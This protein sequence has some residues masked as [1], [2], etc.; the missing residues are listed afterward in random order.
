MRARRSGIG[1]IGW[2]GLAVLLAGCGEQTVE[3]G[4]RLLSGTLGVEGADLYYQTIGTGRPILVVHGGPGLD[5]SYLRPWL[6][7]LGRTHR[8]ILYDQR[9]LGRSAARLDSAGITMS[10]FLTDIDRLRERVAGTERLVLL[11]HS[12]GAIP[13]LL[14]AL[15]AP[16]RV[17]A[18]I[19]VGSVEPGSRYQE[20]TTANQ[21]ERRDPADR[22]AIDSL[23]ASPAFG[24][25]DR[26]TYNRL[27]FHVFRGTFADP[28]VADSLLRLD[29]QPRTARQG[30]TVARRLMGP[31]QGLDF[32][33]ELGRIQAPV[34]LVH[35]AEDPIPLEMVRELE[36][37]LPD[38]RLVVLEGAGHFPFIETPEAFADAVLAFLDRLPSPSP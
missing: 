7:P 1:R 12:W 28:S 2:L 21:A 34:L 19:L 10:R 33:D 5:H 22:E 9:G 6:E 13:A 16:D 8:V 3:S 35:G 25:G 4:P 24:E 18:L 26:G 15:E 11:A 29:L 27:F 38:S 31:L 20:R 30:Q 23:T 17:E 14:Y 32:W 37:A 36:A